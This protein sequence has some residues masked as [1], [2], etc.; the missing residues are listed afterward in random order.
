M[1]PDQAVQSLVDMGFTALE[2]EIYRSLLRLG[3]GTGYRVAQSLGKPAANVYKALESL[4]SKGAVVAEDGEKR[5]YRPVPSGELLAQLERQFARRK[6]RAQ[7]AL[8]KLPGPRQDIRIYGLSSQE[9]VLERARE[10]LRRT[11]RLALI[12]SFPEPFDELT[13]EL[14]AAA[15]RGV[16]VAAKIYAPRQVE[17]VRT[18]LEPRHEEIRDRWPGEWLIVMVD[19][20]EML[21]A[22]LRPQHGEV[23]QAIWTESP[24][25]ATIFRGAVGSELGFTHL[26]ERIAA[27]ASLDELDAAVASTDAFFDPDLPGYFRL[28]EQLGLEPTLSSDSPE[29][30]S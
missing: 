27:G 19:G 5:R 10:M 16:H 18:I 9:Q 13:D 20:S 12:D 2:A 25:L 28:M 22:I 6:E 24:Y 14:Q 23:L 21:I 11:Q 15:A 4:E 8:A 29:V 26:R 3:D 1:S 7:L 17:G 30:R